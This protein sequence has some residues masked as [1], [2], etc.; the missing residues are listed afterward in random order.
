MC[1]AVEETNIESI[2]AVVN[3]TELVVEIRPE[4]KIVITA[5]IDSIFVSSYL[6]V[7]VCAYIYIYIYI[8]C[9]ILTFVI[10]CSIHRSRAMCILWEEKHIN[11][12]FMVY[13]SVSW[14]P[15]HQGI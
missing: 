8:N 13:R 15:T 14:L 10:Q 3:P 9:K 5:R 7:C 11:Y 1:T 6:C 2:L 12:K 4:K